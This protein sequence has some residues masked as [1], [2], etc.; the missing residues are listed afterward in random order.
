M[1]VSHAPSILVAPAG[2][3]LTVA[4]IAA[5]HQTASLVDA[6]LERSIQPRAAQFYVDAQSYAKYAQTLIK[7]DSDVGNDSVAPMIDSTVLAGL[8]RIVSTPDMNWNDLQD[9]ASIVKSAAANAADA[10][11][12]FVAPQR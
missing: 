3:N 12:L 10:L 11:A 6:A 7:S 5:L 4:A 2:A 8:D 9:E 1:N